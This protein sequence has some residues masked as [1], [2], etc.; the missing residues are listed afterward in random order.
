MRTPPAG[1]LDRAALVAAASLRPV[2]PDE[3]GTG[4]RPRALLPVLPWSDLCMVGALAGQKA[5]LQ[6]AGIEPAGVEGL[7]PG[8]ADPRQC[9]EGRWIEYPEFCP[10]GRRR[11]WWRK[12]HCLEDLLQQLL[13]QLL[14]HRR[15]AQFRAAAFPGLSPKKSMG[16]RRSQFLTPD[17]KLVRWAGVTRHSCGSRSRGSIQVWAA[18]P[19][20]DGAAGPGL[21]GCWFGCRPSPSTT[22]GL[23]AALRVSIKFIDHRKS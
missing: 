18:R 10:R 17:C 4:R 11:G 5:L 2:A 14:R 13:G 12:Q 9:T 19:P 16:L 1:D 7:G 20:L 21:A 8:H 6:Q 22:A 15:R 3:G 23:H